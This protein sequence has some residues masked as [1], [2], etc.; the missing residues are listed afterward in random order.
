MV[1]AGSARQIRAVFHDSP[2]GK[3]QLRQLFTGSWI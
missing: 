2:A 3:R 1:A